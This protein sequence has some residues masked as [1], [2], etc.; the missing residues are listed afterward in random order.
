MS[1]NFVKFMSPLLI[2]I[3]AA[4]VYFFHDR[5]VP[6]VE[7]WLPDSD[8]PVAGAITASDLLAFALIIL[9]LGAQVI[10]AYLLFFHAPRLWDEPDDT[11]GGQLLRAVCVG[12]IGLV[13]LAEIG[14]SLKLFAASQD[15]AFGALRDSDPSVVDHLI[16]VGLGTAI[17]L[18]T[19][20]ASFFSANAIALIVK[21][22]DEADAE[23]ILAEARDLD[24][25]EDDDG[26]TTITPKRKAS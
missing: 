1:R 17:G 23:A 12:I 22:R 3:D 24:A 10:A 14:L 5:L 9:F 26:L 7:L 11:P 19:V 15:D 16:N 4:L 20:L 13:P 25:N 21:R 2:L 18:I 8:E 6:I